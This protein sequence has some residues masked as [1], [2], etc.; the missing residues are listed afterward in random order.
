MCQSCIEQKICVGA[1]S[2]NIN[3][4]MQYMPQFVWFTPELTLQTYRSILAPNQVRLNYMKGFS[5]KYSS[6]GIAE[7][8]RKGPVTI[9]KLSKIWKSRLDFS[10]NRLQEVWLYVTTNIL[11]TKL[12]KIVIDANLHPLYALPLTVIQVENMKFWISIHG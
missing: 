5:E 12:F 2:K 10:G 9:C 6:A 3:W 4:S 8:W 7:R 1:V 11:I